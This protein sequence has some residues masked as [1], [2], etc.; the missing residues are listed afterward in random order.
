MSRRV[1]VALAWSLAG[2]S[3]AMFVGSGVLFV[4]TRV[5]QFSGDSTTVDF[6]SRLFFYVPFLAFPVVGA[7]VASRRPRNAIGWICL[8]SGLFWFSPALGD[9]FIAYERATTDTPM[10]SAQAPRRTDHGNLAMVRRTPRDLH[11]PLFPDGRLPSRRWRPFA[12]FAGAVIALMPA[13]FLL[14]V[15]GEPVRTIPLVNS[16]G[17]VQPVCA[18]RSASLAS[19][20]SLVLRYR[21]SG[22][23]VREQ[24]K[25]LAF[26]ASL[27]GMVYFGSIFTEAAPRTRLL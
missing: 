17:L 6:F 8:L 2:L 11:N 7:L 4:L 9:A 16:R 21:R 15:Q 22:E 25:W 12:L 26:A 1:T 3:V 27:V 24:I 20:V 14:P 23:E 10:F 13:L 18:A 19:A 5:E